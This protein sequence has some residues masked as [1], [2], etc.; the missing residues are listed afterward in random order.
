MA[1]PGCSWTKFRKNTTNRPMSPGNWPFRRGRTSANTLLPG[2]GVDSPPAK[3]SFS[4]LTCASNSSLADLMSFSFEFMRWL[5]ASF[6]SCL[7]SSS[8]LP[9]PSTAASNRPATDSPTRF[10]K[11][12][13]FF[14]KY[15]TSFNGLKP[16]MPSKG[17]IAIVISG[18]WLSSLYS[19]GFLAC[20]CSASFLFGCAWIESA[21]WIERTLKRK[22]SFWPYFFATS[23]PSSIWLS[24]TRSIRLRFVSTS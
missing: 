11:D 8:G 10:R 19:F 14:K 13:T 7:S 18:L 9:L 22:G 24:C 3:L 6:S 2:A 12:L 23:D 21:F 16:H 15:S 1:S 17:V 4:S 5:K 20:N